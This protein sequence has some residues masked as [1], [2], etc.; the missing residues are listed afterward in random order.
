MQRWQ[1]ETKE[2]RV[3]LL[4]RLRRSDPAQARALV[5]ST[6]KQ[7]APAE[8]AE[9]V[10]AFTSGLSREDEPFLENA[11][12]Q[13]IGPGRNLPLETKFA[14]RRS[15]FALK[16]PVFELASTELH[17]PGLRDYGVVEARHQDGAPV[18]RR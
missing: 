18:G 14:E 12:V 10:A 5:E 13:T 4:H 8:R 7:D 11:P 16:M 9:F 2:E 15:A 3:A 1:T 17:G 6:W